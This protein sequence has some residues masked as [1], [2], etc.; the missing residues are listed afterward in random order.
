[1]LDKLMPE[2]NIKGKGIV[3]SEKENTQIYLDEEN[4]KENKNAESEEWEKI[5]NNVKKLTIINYIYSQ[6]FN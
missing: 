2:E 1:M 6:I 5:D 4:P 3:L